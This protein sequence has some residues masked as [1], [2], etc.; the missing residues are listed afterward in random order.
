[1]SSLATDPHTP[2]RQ[3]AASDVLVVVED[4]TLRELIAA[5]LRHHG[6]IVL[7]VAG[8]GDACRLIAQVR[9]DAVLLDADTDS[10]RD[11]GLATMLAGEGD[12]DPGIP[13]VLLQSAGADIPPA[14]APSL[15]V[16]KPYRPQALA[17]EVHRLL[18]AQ[19]PAARVPL[20]NAG[21]VE[22]GLLTL[23]FERRAVRV[24]GREPARWAELAPTELR[25]LHQLMLAPERTHS[26]A[27]L[28]DAVWGAGSGVDTRTV[29]QYVRRLREAL[30]PLQADAAVHT[31]RGVGYRL[32]L[33]VL[34]PGA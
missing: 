24:V 18:Q 20:P 33:A 32:D 6:H 34:R 12:G 17:D 8:A 21:R 2:R 19:L 11:A 7:P 30:E 23:D 9:P 13:L 15:C 3:V 16:D 4:A 28:V 10:A 5:H 1:M 31:V 25:L 29:D 14:L 22:V 26:R 27:E